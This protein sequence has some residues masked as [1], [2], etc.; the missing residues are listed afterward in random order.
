MVSQA[1]CPYSE[2]QKLQACFMGGSCCSVVGVIND[3]VVT[4][5]RRNLLSMLG[6]KMD[7]LWCGDRSRPTAG[8]LL[9]AL[10]LH[11]RLL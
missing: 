10:H 8:P 9:A 2:H 5:R 7:P 4:V 3:T 1:M 6:S 11:L